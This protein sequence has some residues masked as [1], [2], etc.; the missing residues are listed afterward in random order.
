VGECELSRRCD[1]ERAL[2]ERDAVE[3]VRSRLS[4]QLVHA[5]IGMAEV[6]AQAGRERS[7]ERNRHGTHPNERVCAM[8]TLCA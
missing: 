8:S 3:Q 1:H 6:I 5:C 4:S 2:T 7:R